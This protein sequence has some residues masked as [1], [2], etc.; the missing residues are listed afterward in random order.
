MKK[1]ILPVSFFLLVFILVLSPVSAFAS[2]SSSNNDIGIF[3]DPDLPNKSNDWANIMTSNYYN[4]DNQTSY[5]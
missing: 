1:K 2:I 4:F 5:Y 3:V